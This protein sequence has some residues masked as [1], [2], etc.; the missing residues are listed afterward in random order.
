MK[1]KAH[2][3]AWIFL[4]TAVIVISVAQGLRFLTRDMIDF[5][6]LYRVGDRILHGRPI[7]D[8]SD[9]IMLFKYAPIIGYVLT[10]LAFLP[11]LQSAFVFF[12]LSLMAFAACFRLSYEWV[13]PENDKAAKGWAPFLVVALT[14]LSTLRVI[15]NS[16]DFG[17]V[18][19]F[20]L[21]GMLYAARAFARE[22]N[23]RGGAI[24]SLLTL[25]KIVPVLL[26]VPFL[27]RKQFKP[28]LATALISLALLAAPALW[29]GASGAMDLTGQWWNVLRVT[30]N[31]SMIERWTNQSLL[32]ALERIL[33]PNH[34]HV[35]WFAW[36]P[37]HVII[38]TNVILALWLA[39][40]IWLGYR[41]DEKCFPSLR[42]ALALDVS[43][44]LLLIILAFPLAW[45]YHF[46]S[47]IL[48]NMLVLSYLLVYAKR[49]YTVWG[50]FGASLLLSSGVNQEILGSRLFEWFH[51]RSCL[52]MSV[53]LTAIALL[54]IEWQ[55]RR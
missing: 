6:V 36:D 42:F 46:T 27:I 30:T 9:G 38:L 54:R 34:Y 32:S 55:Y 40:I 43:H 1:H 50:L 45:R 12:L 52:T 20:L 31:Q 41:R 37:R 51:L 17:Q 26:C 39:C 4:L 19:V 33:A 16:L 24:L 49:D 29:L 11:K 28:A 23:L 47:M 53:V 15:M 5:S 18:Q 48:P 44:Y 14:L 25:S 22:K 13:M 2:S 21:V 8:F 3:V 35:N 10:P 7:Y